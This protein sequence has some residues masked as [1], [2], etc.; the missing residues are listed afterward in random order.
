MTAFHA[1]AYVPH[2]EGGTG[3]RPLLVVEMSPDMLLVGNTPVKSGLPPDQAVRASRAFAHRLHELATNLTAHHFRDIGVAAAP[4]PES[5]DEALK[6]PEEVTRKLFSSLR[7]LGGALRA[8]LDKELVDQLRF[9]GFPIGDSTEEGP[10]VTFQD[11]GKQAPVLWEMLFEI[12]GDSAGETDWRRFW[13][14]RVPLAH[15]M[16]FNRTDEI[17]LRHGLFA[18]IAEDLVFA[19]EEIQGLLNHLHRHSGGLPHGSL[20]ASFRDHVASELSVELRPGGDV[21]EWLRERG[22][23]WLRCFLDRPGV[24]RE[25]WKEAALARIFN[26]ERFRWDLLHFACH[27]QPCADTEFLSRL[28][29]RVAGEDVALEVSQLAIGLRRTLRSAQDPGPLV[30]LNACGTGQQSAGHEPPGFPRLWIRDRG[31]LAVI[32]TLCPVPDHFAHAFA[33]DFY[34]RLFANAV[35][36]GRPRSLAEVLLDSRRHFLKEYNNPL[37]LAYVL[38][39]MQGARVLTDFPM[40]GDSS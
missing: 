36:P 2:S 6:V 11:N 22:G 24:D 1:G 33:R 4:R 26:D 23:D 32:A 29:M 12:D 40:S 5:T 28:Q 14:F 27:C 35:N 34:E 10:A 20:A 19:G 17:R 38:Y 7:K 37:G 39:A 25:T 15:W 3:R 30:F 13:G 9:N 18:S 8:E 31:A 16:H 21:E